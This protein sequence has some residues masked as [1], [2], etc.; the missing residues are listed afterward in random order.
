VTWK[1]LLWPCTMTGIRLSI[2]L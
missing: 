1:F 2:I